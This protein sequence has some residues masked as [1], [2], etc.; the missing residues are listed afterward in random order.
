MK[1]CF[2]KNRAKPVVSIAVKATVVHLKCIRYETAAAT[3]VAS[4][5]VM[6]AVSTVY[7]TVVLTA[8]KKHSGQE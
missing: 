4:T 8:V 1:R 7:K 6:T 3:V 5:V 2:V